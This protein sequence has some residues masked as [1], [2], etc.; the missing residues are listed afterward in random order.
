MKY[1]LG[2][3]QRL[4]LSLYMFSTSNYLLFDEPSSAL[5][6]KSIQIFYDFITELKNNGKLIIFPT[7]DK[8]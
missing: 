2:M 3:K 6:K 8:E 7:H 5:D 1:S 4:L